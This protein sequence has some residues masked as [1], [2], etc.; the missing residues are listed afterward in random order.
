MMN[1]MRQQV[2]SL[3]VWGLS[4]IHSGLKNL[5]L[6]TPC[7]PWLSLSAEFRFIASGEPGLAV[8]RGAEAPHSRTDPCLLTSTHRRAKRKRT[9]RFG[10][11]L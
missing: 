5:N 6:C 2:S 10:P 7:N 11:V 1:S 4:G 8:E 9:G 3:I